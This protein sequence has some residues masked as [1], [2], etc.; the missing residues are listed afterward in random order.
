MDDWKHQ[1]RISEA[2]ERSRLDRIAHIAGIEAEKLEDYIPQLR[3]A[4]AQANLRHAIEQASLPSP[5]AMNDSPET[6]EST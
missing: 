1:Q 6:G 3:R 5:Q 2:L 4:L